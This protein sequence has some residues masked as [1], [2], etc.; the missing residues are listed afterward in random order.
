MTQRYYAGIGARG[1]PPDVLEVMEELARALARAGWRLRSGHAEGADQAFE[2]G[3]A[4]RADLFLPWSG[5][6]H[7]PKP[8][9]RVHSKPAAFAYAVA[10]YHHPAWGRLR[11]PARAMM[12]RNVHQVLGWP[13]EPP[14]AFVVCWTPDAATTAGETGPRTGGTG[15]AIRLADH[16]EIPVL[17]LARRE[18]RVRAERHIH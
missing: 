18:H 7:R 16:H 13:D 14:S 12:A 17:N 8:V 4:G 15:Q 9:G 1:T 10:R 2:R 11:D 5:F 3:A 6:N